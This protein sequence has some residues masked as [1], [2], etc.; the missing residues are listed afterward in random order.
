MKFLRF[1]IVFCFIILSSCNDS[2]N[3]I[4][5]RCAYQELSSESSIIE[6]SRGHKLNIEIEG[7]IMANL[8]K[9]A[10]IEGQ[11][12]ASDSIYVGIEK[13]IKKKDVAYTPDFLQTH[14]AIIQILCDIENQLRDKTLK[15]YDRSMLLKDKIEKRNIYF[16][17]LLG[18]K[19]SSVEDLPKSPSNTDTKEQKKQSDKTTFYSN[20]DLYFDKNSKCSVAILATT[21]YQKNNLKNGSRISEILRSEGIANNALFFKPYFLS[22]F[23]S[24][25]KENDYAVFG[26]L[27]I[28]KNVNCICVVNESML[29]FELMTD[30]SIPYKK[31][32]A[33]YEIIF[34][35][36][37]HG[38]PQIFQIESLGSGANEALARESL[39]DNF[40]NAFKNL[41]INFNPCKQ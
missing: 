33:S 40:S 2:S 23:S 36:L 24:Q 3:K 35:D 18:K 10:T 20:P 17:F 32:S 21:N 30:E 6:T 34:L 4:E 8:K 16:D 27:G 9:L 25:L 29:N 11:V 31:A 37:N 7:K 28:E 22:K 15:P 13:S 14:N 39:S 26:A 12:K 1:C 19:I 5:E 38:N 41:G